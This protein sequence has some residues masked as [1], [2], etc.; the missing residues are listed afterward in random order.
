VLCGMHMG[1]EKHL[2][3]DAHVIALSEMKAAS[4]K[5]RFLFRLHHSFYFEEDKCCLL[6]MCS[7]INDV[8]ELS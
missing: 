2:K 6:S 8:R 3:R 1:N 5:K 7:A 4:D